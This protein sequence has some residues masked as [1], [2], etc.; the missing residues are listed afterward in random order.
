MQQLEGDGRGGARKGSLEGHV[1]GAGRRARALLRHA[2]CLQTCIETPRSAPLCVWQ[3]AFNGYCTYLVYGVDEPQCEEGQL[4]NP[5]EVMEASRGCRWRALWSC[6][7][8]W[9]LVALRTLR[10]LL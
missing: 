5:F 9:L 10:S 7:Q 1:E 3:V 6:M 4:W 8:G 2:S